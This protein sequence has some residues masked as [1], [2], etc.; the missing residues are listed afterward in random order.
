MTKTHM[1]K[2]T[3]SPH[4]AATIWTRNF[5]LFCLANLL[6]STGFYSS[7]PVFPLLLEDTFGL[8][9]IVLGI[10]VSTYT[11]SA[12]LTR[13]PTGYAL[14]RLGR[15]PVLYGGAAFFCCMYF[16]YP[17]ASSTMG[18]ALVRFSHGAL[19]G[20]AMS[21][22]NTAVVDIL[23]ASR[24]GEGIGYFGL[25][26][27]FGM[28]LGPAIGTFV[29]QEYG[30]T[31]LFYLAG[32]ITCA[33]FLCLLLIGFPPI[34]KRKK[35][36][37]LNVLFEKT[38]LPVSLTIFFMTIPYGTIM[39]FT[40]TFART[41]PE[42]KVPQFFLSL[43][44]GTAI[45]RIT[46][47]RIFDI[48]G[49]ARIMNVSFIFLAT[50]LCFLALH[51]TPLTFPLAGFVYGL[52]FGISV[53]IC[54]AMINALVPAQRRGAA[55]AT[56]M[57]SFDAGIFFGLLVSSTLQAH[58]GW[59]GAYLTLAG[60]VLLSATVFNRIAKKQYMAQYH[61]VADAKAGE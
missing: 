20:V 14:D 33:G 4:H 6:N 35:P 17:H 55:N 43:A 60:S 45:A 7:M 2:T 36:I 61:Q 18:I 56:F 15:R 16:F 31:M 30:F 10:V 40:A 37:S 25:T 26:M 44:I 51:A 38:S 54:Q 57:T 46:A 21:A 47:G 9:G 50:A 13:P 1:T 39:N 49:P 58:F 28:A 42:A 8:S 5:I 32:A 11:V 3:R 23:P 19:W 41:I 22:I 52:G 34:P 59:S 29:Q 53:P 27:I 48:S 24:R 12:I